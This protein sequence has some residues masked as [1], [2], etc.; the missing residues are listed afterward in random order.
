V[1]LG[2]LCGTAVD[3][4]LAAAG[5]HVGRRV[6]RWVAGLTD[7]EV[8]VLRLVA[9]GLPTRQVARALTI[10]ARTADHHIESIYAKTGVSTRAAAALFAVQHGL[11]GER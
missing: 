7:R 8:E 2:R 10:S 11:V 4:V 9:Q 5:Q 6:A 1:R 3:A